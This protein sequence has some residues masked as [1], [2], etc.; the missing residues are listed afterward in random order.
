MCRLRRV[1]SADISP[2][3]H[4]PSRQ[5]SKLTPRQA[6]A[7]PRRVAWGD[8]D[9]GLVGDQPGHSLSVCSPV[10]ISPSDA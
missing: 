7:R 4:D 3:H 8:T 2:E 5:N 1:T 6:R 9:A 10:G